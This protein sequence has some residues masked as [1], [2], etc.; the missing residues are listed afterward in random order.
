MQNMPLKVLVRPLQRPLCTLH[1]LINKQTEP[2]RFPSYLIKPQRPF[3]KLPKPRKKRQK[4]LGVQFRTHIAHV[5]FP[6][7]EIRSPRRHRNRRRR[8]LNRAH[9]RQLACGRAVADPFLRL[10]ERVA[11]GAAGLEEHEA[12]ALGLAGGLVRDGLAVLDFA[13]GGERGGE[14][15]AGGV[16]AEAMYEDLAVGG[17]GVGGVAYPVRHVAVLGGCLDEESRDLMLSEGF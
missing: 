13:V 5:D 1:A 14:G 7:R 12:I 9:G 15:V 4:P 11:R 8:R 2:L 16:P 3:L 6:L 17:V 10:A